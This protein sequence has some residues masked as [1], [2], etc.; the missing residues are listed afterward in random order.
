MRRHGPTSGALALALVAGCGGG[1]TGLGD[2]AQGPIQPIVDQDLLLRV[3]AGATEVD[4]GKAFPLTVVR[5]WSKELVP[6]HWSDE[7]LLPLMVRLV[8]ATHREDDR[9]VEETRRYEGYAF[10]LEDITV[11]A[12]SFRARPR[13]GGSDLVVT[14]EELNLRVRSSLNTEAPGSAELPRG[15]FPAPF[16]RGF[17][18][19]VVGAGI[20]ALVMVMWY[21]RWRALRPRRVRAAPKL[22]PH[23]RALQRL[24]R[25]RERQPGGPEQTRAY[26]VEISGLVRSYIEERFTV[27]APEMTTDEF[28]VEARAID[29]LA[30]S[31]REMLS[32][33]LLLCDLA[34]FARYPPTE[35][36][37]ERWLS[38]VEAFVRDTGEVSA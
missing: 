18:S 34:K 35:E 3:T 1:P 26:H 7:A 31:H 8:D 28:L 23:E 2:L 21:A 32:E 4:F 20:A 5:V 16:P 9:R 29:T 13:D 11:P 6:E 19:G 37:R 38:A 17:W 36:E 12:T 24:E 10:S 14:G 30:E 25:L 33:F 15:P 22:A 27:R